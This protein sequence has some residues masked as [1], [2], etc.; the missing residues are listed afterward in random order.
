M[1]H[2]LSKNE[3]QKLHSAIEVALRIPF[4]AGIEGFV[5]ESIFH[6]VKGLQPP[7]PHSG[8]R[9]KL[10]FDAVDTRSGIGWS[11]KSHQ[12]VPHPNKVFEVVIARADIL[13]KKTTLGFPDLSLDSDPSTLG[14]AILKHWIGKFQNDKEIQK[15]MRPRIAILV[16]TRNHRHYAF[17]EQDLQPLN[18]DEIAWAW[19][20]DK[21][22]GLQGRR[23]DT[24]QIV[25]RWYANQ[26][27]LFES[28]TI[29]SQAFLFEVKIQRIA[30]EKFIALQF[31]S[32]HE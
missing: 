3:Q 20:R 12:G 19:T 5:L 25:Y 28:F 16:K 7:D 9:K 10:L 14:N 18:A 4:I 1:I 32:A 2:Q 11:L 17:I 15:V 29:T 22:K 30:P 27:Q 24:G 31:L 26:K 13:D 8:K 21:R 6:H 23:K